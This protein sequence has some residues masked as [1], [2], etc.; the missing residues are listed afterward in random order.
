MEHPSRVNRELAESSTKAV[1]QV[2][3]ESRACSRQPHHRGLSVSRASTSSVGGADYPQAVQSAIQLRGSDEGRS[4]VAEDTDVQQDEVPNDEIH[5]TQDETNEEMLGRGKRVK[6]LSTKLCDYVTHTIPKNKAPPLSSA[7]SSSS[8][9]IYPITYF[10]NYDRFS[11]KHRN[12]IAAVTEARI[13][14]TFQE[15]MRHEGWR[16]A[17]ASE[18]KAL[19]DQGTWTLETLP[20]GNR[21][22]GSKW[23]YIEKRDEKGKLIRLKA[24]LVCLGNHQEEGI[25]YNETFAL[26]AKM[27]TVCTFLVVA[28]VKDWEVHQMD[29]HNAFFMEIWRRRFT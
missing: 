26:V 4:L 12:C 29:V 27:S 14:R 7:E 19:E 8:G 2:L 9:T 13:P 5:T 21:A 24:R 18:I 22:L 25:D 16:D 6:F 1:Q 28:A 10:L 3:G 11:S 23:V 15:A 17:M 20:K